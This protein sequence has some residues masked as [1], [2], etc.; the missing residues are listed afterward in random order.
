MRVTIRQK[1]LEITPALQV[2]IEMKILKPLR[3]LLKRA[4]AEDLPVFDLELGRSSRHHQKGKVY[5]GAV[6]LTLGRKMIRAEADE[7]DIHAV[8]DLLQEELEREILRFKGRSVSVARR[9]SRKIKKDFHLDRA[10][11]LHR[12]GRIRS[13]GN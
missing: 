2:Y 12:T 1:N 10:A 9:I 5:H 11:R 8:C 3:R 6:T 13:E 7:E 4:V